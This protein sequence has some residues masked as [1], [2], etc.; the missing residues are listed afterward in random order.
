MPSVPVATGRISG[1]FGRDAE[2]ERAATLVEAS[3]S[4]RGRVL[5]VGGEGGIG[6]TELVRAVI[7]HARSLG[8]TAADAACD[9]AERSRPF[10]AIGRALG[11]DD[12]VRERKAIGWAPSQQFRLLDAVIETVDSLAAIRPVVIAIDDMHWADSGTL[13]AF[14]HLAER[15]ATLPVMLVGAYRPGFGGSDLHRLLERMEGGGA[16]CIDLG[17][18]SDEAV[19]SIAQTILGHEPSETTLLRLRGAGGNPL[20][21]TEFVRTSDPSAAHMDREPGA[22]GA[23][24]VEFRRAVLRKVRQLPENTQTMLRL[25]STLGSTFDPRDLVAATGSSAPELEPS[26]HKSVTVGILEPRDAVLAFRHDLVRAALYDDI[27][28]GM[29]R[30]IHRELGRRLAAAGADAIVV[31][32]HLGLATEGPDAEVAGWLHRA[33]RETAERSPEAAVELLERCRVVLPAASPERVEVLTEL[34]IAYTWAGRVTEAEELARELFGRWPDAPRSRD[35]RAA[36]I[37]ALTWQGR[38]GEAHRHAPIANDDPLDEPGTL[39]LA[40]EAALAALLS[41]DLPHAAALAG[42][43]ERAARTANDELALC[44]ALCVQ[45]WCANFAGRPTDAVDLARRAIVVADA[46]AGA[47]GHLAHPCFFVGM[48]LVVLDRLDEAER[49]LREGRRLA[50]E[51]GHVWA[52]PLFHAHLGVTKFAS[53]AWDEAIAEIESGLAIADELGLSAPILAAASAWLSVMQVHRNDLDGAQATVERALARQAEGGSRGGPLLNWAQA[54]VQDARGDT[55]RA[56]TLLDAA[57]EG[58][59]TG[60]S[61]GDAW[62][63]MSMVRLCVGSGQPTRAE[64]LLP[65]VEQAARAIDTPLMRGQALRCRA[66][67]HDDPALALAAVQEYRTS[68]RVH[69]AAA[70]CEDAAEILSRR[71]RLEESVAL[72]DEALAGYE[73]VGA[74]RDINR[75]RARLRALGVS[76]RVHRNTARAVS[77]WASL[78][79]AELGVADLVAQRLSNPEIAERL[80]LSRHTVESHLKHIYR[81][82][83]ISSRV[84]LARMAAEHPRPPG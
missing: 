50:S 19:A 6:K 36:Y 4:G 38:A 48:P 42:R 52:L 39:T 56:L 59:K 7:D 37:R 20:F 51:A 8:C 70:A 62:S 40:S 3:R 64:V 53:G 72:Y 21:V 66:L 43:V 16:T 63:I 9:E 67:V 11:L 23:V 71:G 74:I 22:D 65:T 12:G 18:L 2:L 10:S 26:I 69:E 73:R 68:P 78:T 83:S 80:F 27:A 57:W 13:L 47:R 15:V 1:F 84:E 24:P 25:A 17:P 60:G 46:S 33:A 41:F 75:V 45:A 34:A 49:L 35:L 61:G 55:E 14:R 31:A 77:G 29:R 54:V 82:L 81:K 5:L 44:Q 79:K 28:L 30:Q 32:H 58:I 76:R